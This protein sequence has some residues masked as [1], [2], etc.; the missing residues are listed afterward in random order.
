M[1]EMFLPEAVCLGSDDKDGELFCAAL[2]IFRSAP[3]LAS[4]VRTREGSESLPAITGSRLLETAGRLEDP[5][6]R[7]KLELNNCTAK[8]NISDNKKMK[9]RRRNKHL[10]FTITPQGY[11]KSDLADWNQI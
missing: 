11:F 7:I 6:D 10:I 2:E 8:S 5:L 4:V 9:K 3:G 1:L